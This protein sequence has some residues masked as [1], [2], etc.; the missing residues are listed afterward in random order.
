M[1][2]STCLLVLTLTLP[3]IAMEQHS[4]K[5]YRLTK[6]AISKDSLNHIVIKDDKILDVIGL[7]GQYE[8]K[9]NKQRGDI[10]LKPTA[11]QQTP[12]TVFLTTEAGASYPLLLKPVERQAQTLVLKPIK[13][14]ST[15][16]GQPGETQLLD[17]I[18]TLVKRYPIRHRFGVV[19]KENPFFRV[20]PEL[21]V[22]LVATYKA[23][24][25]IGRVYQIKNKAKYKLNLTGVDFYAKGV[26]AVAL[27]QSSLL[28]GQTT[29]LYQVVAYE[30]A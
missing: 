18:Q 4:V 19:T 7:T 10:Y 11:L 1:Y 14:K 21:K 29:T 28:A 17:F 20:M 24:N 22:Q 15:R 2:K 9:T 16:K 12:F 23:N 27:G 26:R 6:A 30:S 3:C 25:L 8:L 5:S 13:S